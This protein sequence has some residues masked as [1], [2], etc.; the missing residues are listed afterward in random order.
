MLFGYCKKADQDLTPP[1]AVV[2]VTP[3]T[4]PE[5]Q[6]TAIYTASPFDMTTDW[7]TSSAWSTTNSPMMQCTPVVPNTG[8]NLFTGYI[9]K[10]Y[11]V[12]MQAKYDS[13][14]IY[15]LIQYDDLQKNV[16]TPWYFDTISKGWK[17][18]TNS[19][20]IDLNGILT[21]SAF[22]EDKLGVL[23]NINNSCEAFKTQTCYGSCHI[24]QPYY[25][26][27]GQPKAN[28]SG[29]HY[30]SFQ[31]E[32]IDMWHMRLVKDPAYGTGS[33]EYQDYVGG[34]GNWDTVGGSGNG[35]HVDGV[36][37]TGVGA[38]YSTA[39]AAQGAN[40]QTLKASNKPSLSLTVPMFWVLDPSAYKNGQGQYFIDVVDTASVNANVVFIY[41]VDSMGRL[42]YSTS[43]A[44]AGTPAGV[45]DAN[46]GAPNASDYWPGA[47]TAANYSNVETSPTNG[48]LCQP[49][50][51][52]TPLLSGRGDIDVKTSWTG[53][54]CIIQIRRKLTTD[55]LLKQDIDFKGYH[56]AGDV[57]AATPSSSG[58][59]FQDQPFG[60][61]IF[62]NANY[63]HAIKP[64]LNLHFKTN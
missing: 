1:A 19:P 4:A 26:R 57:H 51:F 64:N 40:S 62:N 13:T 9:G 2:T 25:N 53:G 6:L 42:T 50:S 59:W 35:R 56:P 31:N 8:Q 60:I 34:A 63:Q 28:T 23:W 55:D 33:D 48:K 21:R 14:Y 49:A 18:E 22:A 41:A 43:R 11:S 44:T 38:A 3:V 5:N 54:K 39:L 10:A 32:K 45:I 17:K 37:P 61:A 16:N 30:T 24:F 12:Q 20:T 29:N 58:I 7:T 36:V 52:A 47:M 15:F 27:A 46:V